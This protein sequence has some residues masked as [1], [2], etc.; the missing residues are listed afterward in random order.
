MALVN[1]CPTN[2]HD[3]I[4]AS[5]TLGCKNDTH[6]NNQYLCVPNMEK[7]SLVEFCFEGL[8]GIVEKGNCLEFSEGK[9]IR[10]SCNQF[11]YGCPEAHFYDYEIYKYP[12]CQNISTE[13]RCYVLDPNCRAHSKT[14]ESSGQNSVIY[15]LSILGS[16]IVFIICCIIIKRCYKRRRAHRNK[17]KYGDENIIDETDTPLTEKRDTD[18]TSDETVTSFSEKRDTDKITDETV[19]SLSEKKEENIATEL[20]KS[21][22]EKGDQEKITNKLVT[23]LS[24]INSLK[25][26]EIRIVLIGKTGSGKSATGNT[27]LGKQCFRESV[28]S[29]TRKC[30]Q[31]SAVRFGQKILVVETPGVFDTID[32]NENIQ[33][34]ILKCI[35]ISSPGPHAFILVVKI[36]RLTMEEQNSL[37]HFVTYFG[38][39]IFKYLI[40][41]FTSKDNLD[42]VERSF[43]DHIKNAPRNLQEFIE[44]CGKR[45]IAFNNRLKGKEGDKQVTD[46]LS[47]IISNVK[48]NNGEC[49]TN[50]MYIKAEKHLQEKETEKRRNSQMKRDKELQAIEEERSQIFSREQAERLIKIGD[51]I[52]EKYSKEREEVIERYERETT[53]EMMRDTVRN[54]LEQIRD[55]VGTF[56]GAIKSYFS[57]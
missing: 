7:T 11:S 8:M 2:E 17:S 33:Q 52:E 25:E 47:M 41:L 24:E 34:E 35:G 56:L 45:V 46:L 29:V 30:S 20:E 50:E 6:G 15:T 9:S 3:V 36:G 12:A 39:N 38:E 27:I 44:K 40:V 31:T 18:K 19:T 42:Y 53:Q 1:V 10:R 28:A 21:F 5:K 14:E 43:E 54:E 13:L 26:E 22:S 48:A 4:Q 55:G 57:W 23:P 32:T 16:L 51:D 49:Y 37:K